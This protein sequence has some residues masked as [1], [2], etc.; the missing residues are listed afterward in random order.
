MLE[1]ITDAETVVSSIETLDL[2]RTFDAVVLGSNLVNTPDDTQRQAFLRT[3]RRHMH[4]RSI[5]LIEA[6]AP[7]RVRGAKT[8]ILSQGDGINC[9][10]EELRRQGALFRATIVYEAEDAR[11][12]Q[13]F[14]AKLLSELD[15][16]RELERADL[17]FQQWRNDSKSWFSASLHGKARTEHQ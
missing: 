1:A 16:M 12:T 10:L 7:D 11:W 5:A 4:Q 2:R 8:G 9:Y 6:Y 13:T 3:C 14:A 15:L 17:A